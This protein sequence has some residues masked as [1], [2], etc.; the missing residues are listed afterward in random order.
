[1]DQHGGG[2][3][4]Y[5]RLRSIDPAN[6]RVEGAGC[7]KQSF[8]YGLLPVSLNGCS[9]MLLKTGNYK[10]RRTFGSNL[11]ETAFGSATFPSFFFTRRAPVFPTENYQ[12]KPARANFFEQPRRAA[13]CLIYRSVSCCGSKARTVSGENYFNN[14]YAA[15]AGEG[16]RLEKRPK[17]K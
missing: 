3:E 17:H 11:L 16:A 13:Q 6:G 8:F 9:F 7:Q 1:M 4:V 15:P 10:K 14:C 5:F 2:F 12:N